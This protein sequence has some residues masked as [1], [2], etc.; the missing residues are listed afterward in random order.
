MR[1]LTKLLYY[2]IPYQIYITSSSRV[3]PCVLK[4]YIFIIIVSIRTSM[5]SNQ[6]RGRRSRSIIFQFS[7]FVYSTDSRTFHVHMRHTLNIIPSCRLSTRTRCR[8]NNNDYNKINIPKYVLISTHS[9]ERIPRA[10][11][12]GAAA[13]EVQSLRANARCAYYNISNVL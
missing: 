3:P 12:D 9:N 13:P 5:F 8:I 7:C 10:Y 6:M 11:S 2:N 4:V 1:K